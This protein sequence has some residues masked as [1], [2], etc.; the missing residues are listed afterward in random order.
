MLKPMSSQICGLTALGA[1]ALLAVSGCSMIQPDK[2]DYKSASQGSSLEVPPDLTQLP[3]QSRYNVP[4]A[5]VSATGYQATQAAT[6]TVGVPT[7]NNQI[8]DVHFM[9]EGNER[10]LRV[11]R[12]A[13]KVWGPTRD[14]WLE[15]GFL[16][17]VDQRNIGLMEYRIQLV[18][19]GVILAE[20]DKGLTGKICRAQHLARC[21]RMPLRQNADHIADVHHLA[22]PD[23]TLELAF[24]KTKV[25]D[26]RCHLLPQRA[27]LVRMDGKVN[28]G[29]LLGKALDHPWDDG[30]RIGRN[31]C[32]A[33]VRG[34]AG[35]DG[36]GGAAARR[37][38]QRAPR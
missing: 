29:P 37:G 19:I 4:G 2:I 11:D 25:K 8:G 38:S 30:F 21:Q 22:G 36:R 7:A 17:A 14:F 35:A 9:R 23:L 20:I 16:L 27:F 24:G 32:D 33:K 10:W 6:A 28:S 1:A 31:T 12:P 34:A 18:T 26:L 5:P 3:G 15:S 13:D